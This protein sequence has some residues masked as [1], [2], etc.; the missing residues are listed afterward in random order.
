MRLINTDILILT[1]YRHFILPY[2]SAFKQTGA[3]AGN[4]KKVKKDEV[5]SLIILVE[6]FIVLLQYI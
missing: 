2:F 1:I 6:G 3:K 5:E 4:I